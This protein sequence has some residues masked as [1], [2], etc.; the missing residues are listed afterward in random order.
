MPVSI[1]RSTIIV[2]AIGYT[3]DNKIQITRDLLKS[4]CISFSSM[5]WIARRELAL[6]LLSLVCG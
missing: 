6:A 5:Y 1:H 4:A 3:V 2:L